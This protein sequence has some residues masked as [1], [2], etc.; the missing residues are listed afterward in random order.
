MPICYNCKHF[1]SKDL[2]RNACDAFPQSI[3]LPIFYG[4]VIHVTPYENDN[5]IQFEPT[6]DKD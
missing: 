5:N 3:P 1:H 6:V 2:K 4:D